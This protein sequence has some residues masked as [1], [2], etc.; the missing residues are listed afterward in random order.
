MLT[1]VASKQWPARQ[2]DVSNTFLHGH[3]DEQVFYQQLTGFVDPQQLGA[4]C[5]LSR[6][7]YGL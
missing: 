4:V 7:L 6:S 5:M 1:I 3:L 2:L